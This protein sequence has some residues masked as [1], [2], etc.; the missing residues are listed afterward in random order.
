VAVAYDAEGYHPRQEE[1][2]KGLVMNGRAL[3]PVCGDIRAL[4]SDF[5]KPDIIHVYRSGFPEFPQPGKDFD[6]IKFV[7]TNVFGM[8]DPSPLVD[9]TLFMSEWLMNYSMQRHGIHPSTSDRF[10]FVNNPVEE[11]YT[12]ACLEIAQEWRNE[13]AIIVGR[14]GRPDNGIYHAI[15][16]NAVR[17]LRAAGYDIRFIVMA[18][19]SNMIEDMQNWGIPYYEIAPTTNPLA[20][21]TFYNSLD[22]Y[23]HARADGET[24]GVNIAE[25]M[26]HG[27]PVVTHIAEPSVAG[28]G[29]FQSQTTLV[30]HDETGFVSGNNVGEYSQYIQ[31]LTDD[32]L[33]QTRMGRAGRDKAMKEYHVDACVRKLEKVYDDLVC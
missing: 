23:T 13:D 5:F 30:D 6:N 22:I 26:M 8:L 27:L 16:T 18:P 12:D 14:C 3:I 9:K 32:P 1:F 7:E 11:P 24:F 31:A 2:E 29:V 25:A 10:D 28:M 20:L 15:N 33:L 21:S 17:L 4:T 19:P